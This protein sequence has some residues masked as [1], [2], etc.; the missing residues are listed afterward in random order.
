MNGVWLLRRKQVVVVVWLLLVGCQPRLGFPFV[1]ECVCVRERNPE[2]GGTTLSCLT[3]NRLEVRFF[4]DHRSGP[5]STTV[6]DQVGITGD[7]ALSFFFF[8]SNPLLSLFF[9]FPHFFFTHT[10]ARCF[11]WLVGWFIWLAV[12]LSSSSHT[13]SLFFG[14]CVL[15]CCCLHWR[16]L[17][18]H[19]QTGM[20]GWRTHWHTNNSS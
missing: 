19:T 6:G 20:A 11:T 5:F 10:Y 7:V 1:C 14:V 18:T 15:S 16:A 9:L 8:F 13:H 4:W 2:V 12:S 17:C 3:R